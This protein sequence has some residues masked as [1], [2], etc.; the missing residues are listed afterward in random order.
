[1][2]L[3]S[4]GKEHIFVE[5][6][7][8]L[9]SFTSSYLDLKATDISEEVRLVFIPAVHCSFCLCCGFFSVSRVE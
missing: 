5:Y 8:P 3:I 9:I 1:M 7:L 2:S 6:F 4:E